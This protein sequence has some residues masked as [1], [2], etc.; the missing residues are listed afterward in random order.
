MQA[1]LS[2]TRAAIRLGISQSALSQAIRRLIE[3]LRRALGDVSE[4]LAAVTSMRS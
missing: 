3:T 2:F 4:R 1:I